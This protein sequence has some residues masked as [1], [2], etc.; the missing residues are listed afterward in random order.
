[1]LTPNA[2]PLIVEN[3]PEDLAAFDHWAGWR[4]EFRGGKWTKVLVNAA[5]GRRASSTDPSTWTTFEQAVQHARKNALPGVGFVFTGSPFAGVDLDACRNPETGYVER[6]AA[7]IVTEANSYS[8][9]SPSGTGVKV[10]V[11]GT[12]PPGRRRKGNI[13]MYDSGRFFTV[14]GHRLPGMPAVVGE[15]TEQLAALHH[16]VFGPTPGNAPVKSRRGRPTDGEATG[17]AGVHLD[18]AELIRRATAASNGAKFARLWSGDTGDYATD[19][20]EGRSEADLAL[21]SM[22]AF[23]TGPDEDR[24]DALFRRSGLMRS[25]WDERHYGDGRT[26]GRG[27]I[28]HALAGRSEFFEPPRP[29]RSKAQRVWRRPSHA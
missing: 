6:W 5:S 25:K 13:E 10:F 1:M 3:I 9:V 17:G 4:W 20:N 24:I 22:L 18:D 16:R 23:W 29:S 27:T 21:C 19:G 15:R 7:E 26:Y 14:T 2:L 11:R 12:L 8:E 28:G